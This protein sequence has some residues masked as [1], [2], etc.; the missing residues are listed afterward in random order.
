MM[1]FHRVHLERKDH[2]VMLD[3][4]ADA[5]VLYLDMC[6]VYECKKEIAVFSLIWEK[7][8]APLKLVPSV[9][10]LP[11]LGTRLRP[12]LLMR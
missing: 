5:Y 11:T 3:E 4:M 2:L 10:L 12:A 9:S 1:I 8:N 6:F 7:R